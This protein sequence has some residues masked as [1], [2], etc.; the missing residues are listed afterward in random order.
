MEQNTK[1][2]PYCGEEIMADAKKCRYCGEWLIKTTG[3]KP[4]D[5]SIVTSTTG[6]KNKTWLYVAIAVV[7]VVAAGVLISVYSK[8]DNNVA[9]D[10]QVTA[11]IVDYTIDKVSFDPKS[12]VALNLMSREETKSI[13]QSSGWENAME[14]T[15][16]GVKYAD[17]YIKDFDENRLISNYVPTKADCQF[18]EGYIEFETSSKEIFTELESYLSDLGYKFKPINHSKEELNPA[19]AKEIGA[20]IEDDLKGEYVL[21]DTVNSPVFGLWYQTL[22]QD[23]DMTIPVYF[24]YRLYVKKLPSNIKK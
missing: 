24:T 4:T 19:I 16:D 5:K 10:D 14:S 8:S 23:R 18:G 11:P 2:C 7:V 21:Q 3:A 12:L 20:V 13:L 9:T 17:V 15:A 1:K 6:N 22:Y